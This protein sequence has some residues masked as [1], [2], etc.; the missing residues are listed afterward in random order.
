MVQDHHIDDYEPVTRQA[1]VPPGREG[2][3]DGLQDYGINL[4]S[5]GIVGDDSAEAI[6]S[7]TMRARSISRNTEQNLTLGHTVSFAGILLFTFLVYLRPYE[8]FDWLAWT[9]ATAF[10]VAMF[11]LIVYLPTQLQLEANLTI[12]TR[13]IN[14]AL[15]LVFAGM[16]SVIFA[17]NHAGAWNSFL[18]FAKVIVV[19]VIMVNVVRTEKRLKTLI[20]M[21]LIAGCVLSASAV[22][23]YRTGRFVLGF[24]ERIKGLIGNLFDNP[25]DL[26]LHLVTMIPLSVAL[27][28]GARGGLRKLLYGGSAVLMVA[29]VVATFS[30]GGFIGLLAIGGLLS[31]RLAKRNK[32]LVAVGLPLAL[33]FFIMFAPRGYG[34]RLATTVDDSGVARRDEL[35]RSVYV[36]LYHP[37]FGVGMNNYI[38]FSNLNHASHNAYTQVAS[39]MG[40]PAMVVYI[41]FLVAP[42]KDLRRIA[43][44]TSARRRDPR[45]HYLAYGLE[46]SIVGYMVSS[47]FLSVAYLWYIYYLVG[48]AICFRRM[49]EASVIDIAADA[50]S[51][52]RPGVLDKPPDSARLRAIESARAIPANRRNHP[53]E[54]RASD[55]LPSQ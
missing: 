22:N 1:A 45:F 41:L 39:E 21:M 48:Y 25:N 34:T 33:A 40:I 50:A 42:L 55:D 37:L 2:T 11:T 44:E 26:A 19:F 38:E 5:G 46:A 29:G 8:L 15:L 18:N 35:T 31:W 49:Y 28:M 52:N 53:L 36:A 17:L 32:W 14:L 47:F 43:R 10:W 27:L 51:V 3:S 12:R 4:G 16:I 54:T 30:R 9:S 6:Q 20:L 24:H 13:E 23:D 7:T